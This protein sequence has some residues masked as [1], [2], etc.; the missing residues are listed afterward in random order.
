MLE[1]KFR[2]KHL[3]QIVDVEIVDF[4]F[5]LPSNFILWIIALILPITRHHCT[6]RKKPFAIV[7]T[8]LVSLNPYSRNLSSFQYG[9]VK[10]GRCNSHN[11]TMTCSWKILFAGA[12]MQDQVKSLH[13]HSAITTTTILLQLH[14]Q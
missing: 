14:S 9:L 8:F 3:H 6:Q 1:R 11:D 10:D 2:G 4:A 5:R 12:A 13:Q 7:N